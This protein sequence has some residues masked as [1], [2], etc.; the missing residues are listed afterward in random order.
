MYIFFNKKAVIATGI[1]IKKNGKYNVYK[2]I[3]IYKYN[4]NK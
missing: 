2:Y 1:K 4:N 3:I